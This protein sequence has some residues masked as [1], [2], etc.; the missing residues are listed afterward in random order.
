[1]P[2]RIPTLRRHSASNQGIVTIAGHDHYLGP[3][4]AGKRK[5]PADVKAKYD[6]KI[7]EWL[8]AGRSPLHHDHH[9]ATVSQLLDAFWRHAEQHYRTPAGE[10]STEQASYRLALR[11]VRHLYAGLPAAEFS[12]LKLKA[13]RQ[14]MV[15]GYHHPKYGDQPGLARKV[16][17]QRVGR[18]V[19]AFKWA[20]AEE[21][22]PVEV[23]QALKAVRGLERGRTDAEETEPITPVAIEVVEAT[24]P[25]ALP[26]VQAMVKLQRFTGM[27]PGEACVMR[28]CDLEMTGAVW[29]YRPKEHKTA[30]RGKERVIAIGPQAQE[31]IKPWLKLDTQAFLFSPREAMQAQLA[32]RAAARK[33]LR[34]CGNRPGTNRKKQ[35]RR[36]PGERYDS[37]SYGHAIARAIRLADRKAREEATKEALALGLE[38]PAPE[39]E[40]IPH[41]HPHQLRHTHATEVRKK[42]GLEAAQVA[43][44]HS[45]ANVTQLYAERDLALAI[46][47]AGEIG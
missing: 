44:G 41:W 15:D 33:T 18:I 37:N 23:Y 11:P 26:P 42:Y 21:L 16:V 8:A 17:N 32:A 27:R 10:P 25:F 36:Q 29:I 4:P 24:M 39:V 30:Y 47:V 13:V 1:V 12:P 9:A 14:I 3:W 19:R 46:R 38:P 31:V 34:S 22:I 7:A 2:D 35:P 40:F 5:P 45:Q 28:G 20:V 6:A 43:L